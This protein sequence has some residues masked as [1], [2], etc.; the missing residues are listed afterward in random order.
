MLKKCAF[1]RTI[2]ANQESVRNIH[3]KL[4]ALTIKLVIWFVNG[5]L[6]ASLQSEGIV[7]KTLL[8]CFATHSRN[9]KTVFGIMINTVVR[10]SQNARIMYQ[11]HLVVL[12]NQ[13][14]SKLVKPMQQ[15]LPVKMP[16]KI[17]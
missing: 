12:Q 9:P 13:V 17:A 6:P 11:E 3:H 4:I 10:H 15:E 14:D 1:G 2:P 16:Q 8:K 5:I 7:R